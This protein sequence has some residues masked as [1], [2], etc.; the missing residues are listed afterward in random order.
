[1]MYF[2]SPESPKISVGVVHPSWKSLNLTRSHMASLI[3]Q[4]RRRRQRHPSQ[5][6]KAVVDFVKM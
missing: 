4:N 6:T 5:P 2:L 1:M 3:F